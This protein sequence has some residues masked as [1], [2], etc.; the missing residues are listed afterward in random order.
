MVKRIRGPSAVVK[1]LSIA[2]IVDGAY[3]TPA[4]VDKENIDP[5]NPPLEYVA[6]TKEE[7]ETFKR[8]V[9]KAVEF[10]DARGDQLEVANVQFSDEDTKLAEAQLRAA[11]LRDAVRFWTR[12]GIVLV[13]A[14][15][16]VFL[17]FRPMVRTP[18]EQPELAEVLDGQ[19][20]KASDAASTG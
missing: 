18:T 13:V 5:E 6:R 12:M 17:V 11:E 2:V 10:D 1:R 16:L 14:L 8:L 20:P 4:N 7:I 19:L 9:A 15:L 3:K